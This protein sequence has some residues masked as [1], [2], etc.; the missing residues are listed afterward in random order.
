PRWRG[1][2]RLAPRPGSGSQE[3][4]RRGPRALRQKGRPLPRGRSGGGGASRLAGRARPRPRED[5][6]RNRRAGHVSDGGMKAMAR[7]MEKEDDSKRGFP[8]YMLKE[9]HEQPE[10]LERTL[11]S[12]IQGT[13]AADM[14]GVDAAYAQ[15]IQ[16]VELVACGTS[17]HAA[18][19]AR[20]AF[21]EL[22]GIP[23]TADIASEYR[24]W[25]HRAREGTWVIA[26]TQSGETTDTLEAMRA[27][28]AVGHRTAAISNVQGS[29][30]AREADGALYTLAGTE[31]AIASTKA[32]TCQVAA[33]LAAAIAVGRLRKSLDASRERSLVQALENAPRQV[34][35]VID[36]TADVAR[37]AAR[38]HT[39]EESFF[40]LGRGYGYP[41]AR[42]GALK[43][44]ETS[45]AH[46]EAYPSGEFRHGPKIGRASCRKRDDK[47]VGRG[48][49]N[50]L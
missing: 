25:P 20:R 42:E 35:A 30:I 41:V 14:L 29:T 33:L 15:K 39:T 6:A 31:V 28:K 22:V 27:A 24:D 19:I 36:A 8:H 50:R 34:K 46:A 16:R 4:Q 45:Y 13:S 21:E 48:L 11:A 12:V 49:R 23:A 40:F 47:S 32:C 5:G 1:G 9:I 3:P 44:K 38:A 10:V 7:K 2:G 18:L 26:I 17:W 37:E 43:L